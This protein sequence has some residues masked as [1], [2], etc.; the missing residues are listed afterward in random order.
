MPRG[1]RRMTMDWYRFVYGASYRLGFT[2]WDRG[3]P[4]SGLVELVEGLQALPRGRALD[5][6]C[7][8]GTNSIYLCRKGWTATGVDLEP[9]ALDGARRHA[10]RAGVAPTFVEGDVT[11]L[12]ELGIGT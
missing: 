11:R 9:R 7:G 10:E 5:L 4:A 8:T 2:P 6:G 12:S 1:P 3:V